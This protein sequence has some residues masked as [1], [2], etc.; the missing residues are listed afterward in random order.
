MEKHQTKNQPTQNGGYN[1][2]KIT[3]KTKNQQRRGRNET[4]ARNRCVASTSSTAYQAMTQEQPQHIIQA[5]QHSPK[6]RRPTPQQTPSTLRERAVH[7]NGGGI[8][9]NKIKSVLSKQK[10]HKHIGQKYKC[11]AKRQ[12][13]RRREESGGRSEVIILV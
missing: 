11:D 2:N 3:Q 7:T 12:I 1:P 13:M 10:K 9:D 5:Q 4:T 8:N 6:R